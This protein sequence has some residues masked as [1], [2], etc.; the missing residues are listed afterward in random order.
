M[1]IC[2]VDL[3][4]TCMHRPEH[5]RDEL[6]DA[7]TLLDQRHQGGDAALVIGTAPEMR[8]NELLESIYLILKSHQIGY[9]FIPGE[10]EFRK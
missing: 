2:T 7:V 6:V 9:S 3:S 8:E 4:H 5:A 1:Y 10:C